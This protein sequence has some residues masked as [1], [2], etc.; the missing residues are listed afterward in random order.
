[1]ALKLCPECGNEATDKY[2]KLCWNCTNI[3]KRYHM[4]AANLAAIRTSTQTCWVCSRI[5]RGSIHLMIG[6]EEQNICF[7]CHS[8]LETLKNP[9][10]KTKIMQIIY[11]QVF[12]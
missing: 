10:V 9:E 2:R 8:V 3:H 7:K 12:S 6:G 11:M 4:T 5:T 1:M